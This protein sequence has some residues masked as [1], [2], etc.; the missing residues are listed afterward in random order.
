MEWNFDPPS[1]PIR[2]VHQAPVYMKRFGSLNPQPSVFTGF[3]SLLLL[4]LLVNACSK[5]GTTI[6]PSADVFILSLDPATGTGGTVVTINGGGF[7]NITTDNKVK[8]NGVDA[9]VQTATATKLTVVAPT[10]GQTGVVTVQN[11]TTVSVNGPTFTYAA[12]NE[13][14]VTTYAGTGTGG[15]VLRWPS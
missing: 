13:P 14:I 9:V 2:G 6:S 11:G 8:F 7:S 10:T 15:F 5:S 12:A 4:I 3:A 1:R